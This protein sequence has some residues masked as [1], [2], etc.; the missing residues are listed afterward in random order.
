MLAI[1]VRGQHGGDEELRSV[2]VGAGVGHGQEADTVV[3]QLEVLIGELG[4]VDTLAT[5]SITSGEIT[6]L[7]HELRDDSVEAAALV[8]QVLA[9]LSLALLSSAKS[10]EVLGGLGD[11]VISQDK[12]DSSRLNSVDGDVKEDLGASGGDGIIGRLGH[13]IRL[14]RV[15]DK[16]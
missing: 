16:Y 5:T 10:S 6:T 13:C 2:G 11:Y 8:V 9:G 15:G 14:Y 7:Q 12:L 4:A 3:L 1:K